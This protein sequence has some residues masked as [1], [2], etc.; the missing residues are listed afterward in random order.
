MGCV[1]EDISEKVF[2][3]GEDEDSAIVLE[4]EGNSFFSW[5]DDNTT[6]KTNQ[7]DS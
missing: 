5:P 1:Q 7:T 6:I 3:K 2:V 4:T